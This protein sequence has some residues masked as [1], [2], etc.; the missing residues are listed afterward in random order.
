MGKWRRDVAAERFERTTLGRLGERRDSGLSLT[1][2]ASSKDCFNNCDYPSECRWGREEQLQRLEKEV[3][4]RETAVAARLD[5]QRMLSP[6]TSFAEI[7]GLSMPTI[8]REWSFATSKVHNSPTSACEVED[9]DESGA[10]NGGKLA[11][12][13]YSVKGQMMAC[14]YYEEEDNDGDSYMSD[15][16]ELDEDLALSPTS[17]LE[18]KGD[19]FR[20]GAH[21]EEDGNLRGQTEMPAVAGLGIHMESASSRLNQQ[22]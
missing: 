20:A 15:D 6:R 18:G 13:P 3:L 1:S 17:N 22:L 8:N 4:E 2:A 16:G 14:G 9:A 5:Q 10:Y 11:Y 19:L 7:L 21:G 12:V